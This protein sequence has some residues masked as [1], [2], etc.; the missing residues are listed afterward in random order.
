MP[1]KSVKRRAERAKALYEQKLVEMPCTDCGHVQKRNPVHYRNGQIPRCPSCNTKEVHRARTAGERVGILI[2][3]PCVVCAAKVS[4]DSKY[5]L[6]IKV[7]TCSIACLRIAQRTGII[8]TKPRK[9]G[10]EHPDWKGH[11]AVYYGADWRKQSAAARL[12]DND[13]CRHCNTTRAEHRR[14]LDVHHVVRFL[15]FIS[16]V[17]ANDLSNLITLCRKCHRR[18]DVAQHKEKRAAGIELSGQR[19]SRRRTY[20]L[21][22]SM[23]EVVRLFVRNWHAVEARGTIEGEC[24]GGLIAALY[25]MNYKVSVRRSRGLSI[26]PDRAQVI[27]HRRFTS[28]IESDC[29]A[30][31]LEGQTASDTRC[32][33]DILASG[34]HKLIIAA[35]R[36]HYLD[37]QDV[38]PDRFIVTN[39]GRAGNLRATRR[40]W[41]K[42]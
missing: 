33:A 29:W 36:T 34:E 5:L 19:R 17:E 1:Y 9:K 2:D 16:S 21:F 8:H 10:P 32:W 42:A 6:R 39:T 15:D 4:R 30:F 37:W 12:R 38:D 31:T 20:P 35:E 25:A 23:S 18:A 13:T 40:V 3:R 28:E 41:E 27:S 7:T 26:T 24:V 11:V 14:A 22:A